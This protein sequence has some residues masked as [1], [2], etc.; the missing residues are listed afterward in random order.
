L[1]ILP[2]CASACAQCSHADGG[3]EGFKA[4]SKYILKTK[5]L[6]RIMCYLCNDKNGCKFFAFSPIVGKKDKD[7]ERKSK[8]ACQTLMLDELVAIWTKGIRKTH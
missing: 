1:N 3:G 6:V 2:T 4:I 5:A 8:N 7:Q